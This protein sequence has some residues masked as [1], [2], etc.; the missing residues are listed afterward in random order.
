MNLTFP[1]ANCL[2]LQSI[3]PTAWSAAMVP[4]RVSKKSWQGR[5]AMVT[6]AGDGLGRAVALRLAQAGATV[7]LHGRQVRKLE[8]VYDEIVAAGGAEPALMPL[9][10]AKAS[11]TDLEAI[12]I[13]LR[14]DFRRLDAL[15]HCAAFFTRLTGLTN[16]SLDDMD[17]HWRVNCSVPLAL[18]RAALPLLR[19]TDNSHVIFTGESHAVAPNA[20][21]GAFALSKAALLRGVDLLA[22]EQ[23]GKSAAPSLNY[24]IPGPMDSP[25]RRQSHPADD[26]AALPKPSAVAHAYLWLMDFG[27]SDP[28]RRHHVVLPKVQSTRN[29]TG[30]SG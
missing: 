21:W 7:V 4:S 20:Y 19:E 8:S 24:V 23:L 6:G 27:A 5:V 12:A 29:M 17:Q 18:T 15:I 22:L 30:T 28:Q 25:Q 1:E 9:D 26:F 14:K 11:E 16:Q 3:D 2:A 10:W 13:G